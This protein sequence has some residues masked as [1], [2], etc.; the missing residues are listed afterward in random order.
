MMKIDP[1]IA[2]WDEKKKMGPTE[3]EKRGAVTQGKNW[4]RGQVV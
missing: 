1:T 4:G 2:L 3:T